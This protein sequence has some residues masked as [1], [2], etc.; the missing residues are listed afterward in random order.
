MHLSNWHSSIAWHGCGN[1]S[2]GLK[3][4][5]LDYIFPVSVCVKQINLHFQGGGM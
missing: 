1:G 3:T 5:V 2:I 4:E